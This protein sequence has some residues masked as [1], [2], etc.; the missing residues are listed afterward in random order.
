MEDNDVRQSFGLL[1]EIPTWAHPSRGARTLQSLLP[2]AGKDVVYLSLGQRIQLAAQLATAIHSFGI[3]RWFHKNFNSHKI[4]FFSNKVSG[5]YNFKWP[6]IVGFDISRPD[7]TQ[8]EIASMNKDLEEMSIYLHP[9]LRIAGPSERPKYMR[10]YDIYSLGLVLVEIG[11]WSKLG[12]LM[13]SKLGSSP[14]QFREAIILKCEAQLA[15][16][17]GV[18]YKDLVVN[19]LKGDDITESVDDFYWIVVMELLKC[20]LNC[21]EGFEG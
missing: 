8:T 7:N 15:H 13:K 3:V 12:S 21:Q 14:E 2:P 19:C 18:R 20:P 17:M 9:D 4:F 6:W 11:F 16:F 5:K 10:R 1:F